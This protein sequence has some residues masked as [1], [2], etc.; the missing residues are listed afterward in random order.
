MAAGQLA[1]ERGRIGMPVQRVRRQDQAGDPAFGAR[2]QRRDLVGGQ[3]QAQQLIE[4]G[5]DLVGGEAQVG[6]AH[7]GQLAV[8][9]QAHQRQ[10]RVAR[11][12]ITRRSW[13]G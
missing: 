9:A 13:D 1:D 10:R 2:G 6:G 11:L 8:R 5:L 7:L 12:M 4:E 3:A